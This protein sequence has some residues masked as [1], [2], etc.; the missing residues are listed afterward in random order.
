M[1]PD[2]VFCEPIFWRQ[3]WEEARKSSSYVKKRIR[4][5]KEAIEFWNKLAPTYGKRSSGR[6][7]KR[8]K[9]VIRLLEHEKI[10]T[11]ET[12]ILDIGCGPGTY[13]LPF[14]RQVKSITVLDGALEMCRLLKQRA[15][16]EKLENIKVMHQMWKDVDLEKEGMVN[17]FDL[18]FASMTPAVCNYDTLI[19]LNRASKKF[20]CVISSAG[21]RF[22]PARQELWELI[23]NE[24]D[25]GC[26]F[27]IIYM[28]NLLY[29]M[30]YYPVPQYFDSE[31][32][33]EEPIG[34]AI[35]RLSRSFWLYTKITPKIKEIISDYVKARAVN[36]LFRQET[37]GRLGIM[38]WRVDDA[39]E[40]I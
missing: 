33:R 6:G 7:Q 27:G 35:E 11:P 39:L 4:N 40:K 17:R 29:S 2:T 28:F 19:K 12:K 16:E 24:K 18:V 13:T 26:G 22:S 14:A 36:G 5:E 32:I 8:L 15:E 38:T 21:G 3:A 9:R 23:F 37:R 30:G 34:L 1:E 25:T 20:C 31:R 10:L